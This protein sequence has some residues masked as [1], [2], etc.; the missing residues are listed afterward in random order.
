[1]INERE[2]VL[3]SNEDI[4]HNVTEGNLLLVAINN[5]DIASRAMGPSQVTNGR[6]S[7]GK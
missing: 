1:M 3:L 7:R 2:A 5:L 6:D 4:Y